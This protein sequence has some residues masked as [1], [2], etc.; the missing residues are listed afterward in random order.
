M[1]S[2]LIGTRQYTTALTNDRH[3]MSV[4][5][6]WR[7]LNHKAV[8]RLII[9]PI[10]Q[11][12]TAPE[13]F[14][15]AVNVFCLGVCVWRAVFVRLRPTTVSFPPTLRLQEPGGRVVKKNNV[16]FNTVRSAPFQGGWRRIQR[17]Y[18]WADCGRPGGPSVLCR[19]PPRG[20]CTGT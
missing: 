19:P 16:P 6:A 11:V 9:G 8:S 18:L 13:V 4:T 15:S 2:T 17:Q 5:L 12:L 1:A 7:G 10:L 20:H 14:W 3:S